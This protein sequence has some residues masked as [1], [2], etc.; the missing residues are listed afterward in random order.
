MI[1]RASFLEGLA[2]ATTV[3][4]GGLDVW[5]PTTPQIRVILPWAFRMG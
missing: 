1:S 3:A 5:D 4:T 2:A